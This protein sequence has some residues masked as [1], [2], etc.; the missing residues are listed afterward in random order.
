MKEAMIEAGE[1]GKEG[2][3]GKRKTPTG[4]SRKAI[5]APTAADIAAAAV[6]WDRKTYSKAKA[7]APPALLRVARDRTLERPASTC[8]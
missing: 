2:G 1:R 3:R 7:I 8:F 6:G 4:N 5:R